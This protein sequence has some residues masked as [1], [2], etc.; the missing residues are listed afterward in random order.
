MSGHVLDSRARVLWHVPWCL[1]IVLILKQMS[2]HEGW[3]GHGIDPKARVLSHGHSCLGVHALIT[4]AL[5]KMVS[6]NGEHMSKHDGDLKVH[7]PYC[8]CVVQ[9]W[10]LLGIMS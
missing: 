10:R 8:V 7:V 6:R 2:G 3:S 1:N 9:T 4:K 5:Q